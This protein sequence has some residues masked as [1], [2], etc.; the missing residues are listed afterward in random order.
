[1]LIAF[2]SI[3]FSNMRQ[4][5]LQEVQVFQYSFA[6]GNFLSP[7]DQAPP[8]KKIKQIVFL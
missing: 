8:L 7:L 1:M 4:K 2:S 3:Q 5:L 6:I